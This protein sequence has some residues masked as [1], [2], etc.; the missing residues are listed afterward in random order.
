MPCDSDR[1]C[2][3]WGLSERDRVQNAVRHCLPNCLFRR[4][5]RNQKTDCFAS[6]CDSDHVAFAQPIEY[7][8]GAALM[9]LRNS[10]KFTFG[11]GMALA[12][13]RAEGIFGRVLPGDKDNRAIVR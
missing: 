3:G 7:I 11:D 9:S 6:S 5:R 10:E 8:G 1:V 12:V 2:T 13:G 4:I